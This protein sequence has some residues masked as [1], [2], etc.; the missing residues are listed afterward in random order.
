MLYIL[1]STNTRLN[2]HLHPAQPSHN[3]SAWMS[4]MRG[5]EWLEDNPAHAYTHLQTN[6]ALIHLA[7]SRAGGYCLKLK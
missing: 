5:M 1:P 6:P 3:Q 4:W 7:N 2:G